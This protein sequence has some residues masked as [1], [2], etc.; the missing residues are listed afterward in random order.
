MA[1]PT[2]RVEGAQGSPQSAPSVHLGLGS[3]GMVPPHGADLPPQQPGSTLPQSH[4]G[5]RET[6]WD[7]EQVAAREPATGVRPALRPM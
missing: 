3:R 6:A 4:T 2:A 7:R 1:I 5:A